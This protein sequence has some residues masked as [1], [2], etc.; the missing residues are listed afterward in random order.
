MGLL[1]KNEKRKIYFWSQ[2][3]KKR[4]RLVPK[5]MLSVQV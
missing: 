2:K 5:N 3:I 4:S 1:G